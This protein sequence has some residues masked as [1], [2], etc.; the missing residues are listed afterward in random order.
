M[1]ILIYSVYP[2]SC[3]VCRLCACGNT[4]ASPEVPKFILILIS[5]RGFGDG[6]AS[7]EYW[8]EE[9]ERTLHEDG[10]DL[11][12]RERTVLVK[13]KLE[14]IDSIKKLDEVYTKMVI[15]KYTTLVP[16]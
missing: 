5:V 1:L 14:A 12:G 13:G 3:L 6:R 4:E 16:F 10:R 8:Q 15:F 9:A 7:P 2:L 11:V